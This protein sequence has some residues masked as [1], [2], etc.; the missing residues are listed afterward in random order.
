VFGFSGLAALARLARRPTGATWLELFGAALLCGVGITASL[1]FGRMSFA[2]G[3][4]GDLDE[5]RLGI[6]AGSLLATLAGAAV[7]LVANAWR[8]DQ[9]ETE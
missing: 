1:F 2:G 9:D 7:F 6:F 3:A 4:A 5:A 8:R